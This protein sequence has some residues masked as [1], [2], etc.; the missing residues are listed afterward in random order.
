MATTR[1]S[2]VT[3]RYSKDV[4]TIHNRIVE[5]LTRDHRALH[6]SILVYLVGFYWWQADSRQNY[7]LRINEKQFREAQKQV[8]SKSSGEDHRSTQS[9]ADMFRVNR[10][11]IRAL[12]RFNHADICQWNGGNQ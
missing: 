9:S 8:R 1:Q 6:L 4:K 12:R 11:Q 10:N 5:G 7:R 2:Q 3:N